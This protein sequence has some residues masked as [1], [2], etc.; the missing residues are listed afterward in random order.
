MECSGDH[1]SFLVRYIMM[2]KRELRKVYREKR[3]LLDEGYREQ[4][5]SGLFDQLIRLDWSKCNYL[6]I[7]LSLPK[8]NEPDTSRFIHWIR[9]QHPHIKLVLSKTDLADGSMINY[10]WN[11]HTSIAQNQWGLLEPTGGEVVNEELVDSVLVPLLVADKKGNRIGYGKGF[12][13]R[14]LAKCR[15][16]VRSIGLSYFDLV[17]QIVDTEE[18]DFP[19]KYC[20]TPDKT[21][22]F[23]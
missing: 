12:Y 1:E 18:W 5:D 4:L 10:L 22:N 8:Y 13:D 14:F 21:Y 16:D 20:M 7:F 15:D 2:T 17:E 19:L 11:E 3:L 6:H 23:F 9:H